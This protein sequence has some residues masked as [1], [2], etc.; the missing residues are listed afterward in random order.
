MR[1]Y[2]GRTPLAAQADARLVSLLSRPRYYRAQ[3]PWPSPAWYPQTPL[4]IFDN[5]ALYSKLEEDTLF[6][7]RESC[8]L[9]R[10]RQWRGVDAW[11]R[12]DLLLLA[13]RLPPVSVMLRA[14]CC[15]LGNAC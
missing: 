14:V 3:N 4:N 11:P 6:Y 5:P 13:A 9:A 7:V 15:V 8:P 10:V 12:T 1:A 2:S